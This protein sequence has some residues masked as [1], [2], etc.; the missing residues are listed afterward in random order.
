VAE[1][2]S[3]RD[4]FEHSPDA[5]LVIEGDRF[6]DCNPAAVR[7]LRFPNKAAL[8]ERYS[9][10]T[11]AGGLS[12]HPAEMSPSHQPDGRDSFE[13]AEEFLALTFER[14]S[15]TFEWE[16]LCADGAPL[17][18]EV[19]LTRVRGGE[20]P[21]LHVVWR[22]ISERKRLEAELQRAQRL[23]AVGRLAGG[24]AHDFN[25]LLV[26]IISHAEQL[27]EEIRAGKADP[28]R[29]GEILS[30]AD[31]A[32]DLTRQLLAFSRGQPAQPRATNLGDLVDQLGKLL[33]TLIGE[34]IELDLKCQEG[35]L[36]VVAD[37]SQLEQLVMNLAAN[38]R[39]AMPDGGQ[40][41]IS[42]KRR[43]LTS[44]DEPA[45]LRAG[46]YVALTVADS[47]EGMTREQIDHAFD[48]FYT[49]KLL[50]KGTGLGLA[51]VRAIAEQIGGQAS[52]ASG[53]GRGTTVR[54]LLPMSSHEPISL[55]QAPRQRKS[56]GGGETI[57]LVE[58]EAAIR[59][60]FETALRAKGYR[61]LTAKD[62]Q[63]ALGRV[64]EYGGKIDLLL[65]D[66]VMPRVS[67]PELIR[68]LSTSAPGLKV[69]FMSGYSNEGD[70]GHSSMAETTSVLQKPFSL[71]VLQAKIREILDAEPATRDAE[72]T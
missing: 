7:M 32:A 54:V 56:T 43:E 49:T 66:V 47:G 22:D 23:E 40:L 53:L 61:V 52:I 62:G 20:R 60:L 67:G 29:P 15:H 68:R 21:V 28:E 6:V 71:K 2:T 57:L 69:L 10:A 8:L 35:P 55:S 44:W 38:A 26:V 37:P 18:V 41:E 72:A 1:G 65:T 34:H 14:G 12:A 33:R 48:P 63:D 25:N 64:A 13:K 31:R 50:G 24:V 4:I 30:A 70:L 3:Y 11:E 16:H 5:I 59:Q 36:T 42:V 46:R 39:D 17:L 45:Q 9:G 19:Q 58:D 27:E 51:T